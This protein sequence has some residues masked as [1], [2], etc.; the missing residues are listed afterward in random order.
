MDYNNT[1]C[2]IISFS[3][4]RCN[5]GKVT[6][7]VGGSGGMQTQSGSGVWFLNHKQSCPSEQKNTY[8]F[9][10]LRLPA[11]TFKCF[12]LSA[13]PFLA[14]LAQFP[15]SWQVYAIGVHS[16]EVCC[17]LRLPWRITVSSV[18]SIFHEWERENRITK[19]KTS[20]IPVLNPNIWYTNWLLSNRFP[21]SASFSSSWVLSFVHPL[22]LG[23]HPTAF[24]GRLLHNFL[25]PVFSL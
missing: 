25:C 24:W 18:D 22:L 1:T 10:V 3:A 9:S 12:V 19:C 20:L 11:S 16:R 7:V 5:Y 14:L 8:E 6:Q 17:S 23:F 2:I 4:Q 21:T 13:S 15:F